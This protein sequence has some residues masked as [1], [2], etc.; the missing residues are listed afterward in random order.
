MGVILPLW[1]HV[2]RSGNIWGCHTW[3]SRD[4]APHPTELR[5]A[6]TEKDLAPKCRD[7]PAQGKKACLG[8]VISVAPLPFHVTEVSLWT[9]QAQESSL[10]LS[11]L[12][13]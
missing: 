8:P 7:C 1:R 12:D 9:P 11:G 10:P 4:A 3:A 13:S 6:G 5:T 2:A